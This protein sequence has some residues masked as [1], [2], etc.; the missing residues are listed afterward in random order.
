MAS[1]TG[2]QPQGWGLIPVLGRLCEGRSNP[3]WGV[4]GRELKQASR[5]ERMNMALGTGAGPHHELT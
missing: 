4:P 1:N 2:T 5:H 3:K